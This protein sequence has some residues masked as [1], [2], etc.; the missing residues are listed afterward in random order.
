[1]RRSVVVVTMAI[2]ASVVTAAPSAAYLDVGYDGRDAESDIRS[3]GRL[4]KRIESGRVVRVVIRTHEEDFYAGDYL[5][6]RIRLTRGADRARTR[7]W[8]RRLR[9]IRARLLAAE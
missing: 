3:T 5:A 4:V 6:I 9:H 1:M 7:R 8:S 2:V